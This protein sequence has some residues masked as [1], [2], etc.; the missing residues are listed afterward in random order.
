MRRDSTANKK[1]ALLLNTQGYCL[2]VHKT[3]QSTRDIDV[4]S[5]I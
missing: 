5:N 4:C 2:M 3:K 1:K